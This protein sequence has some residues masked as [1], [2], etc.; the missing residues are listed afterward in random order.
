M[1]T[2]GVVYPKMDIA[3]PGRMATSFFHLWVVET[4]PQTG[5]QGISVLLQQREIQFPLHNH[6]NF[7][8]L[9][10]TPFVNGKAGDPR[11]PPETQ[12]REV[13]IGN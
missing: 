2:K 12:R 3:V 11:Y 9:S 10:G 4:M 13:S 7:K 6:E 8:K 5:N 1:A